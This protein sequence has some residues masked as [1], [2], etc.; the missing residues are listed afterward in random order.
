MD[1]YEKELK[2]LRKAINNLDGKLIG[3]IKE[4]LDIVKKIGKLKK[5]HGIAIADKLR[6]QEILE[7]VSKRIKNSDGAAI[8][9]RVFKECFKIAKKMQK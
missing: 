5:K 1:I 8:V 2:K 3:F 4:R 6:E 7:K 9:K